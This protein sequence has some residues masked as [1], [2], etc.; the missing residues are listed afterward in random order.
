MSDDTK[1][2]DERLR[3]LRESLESN[4]LT[5]LTHTSLIYCL[6]IIDQLKDENESLWFMLEEH[7]NSKWTSEHSAELEKTIQGQLDMLKLMQMRKGEA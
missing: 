2:D 7:K 6:D 4:D 1:Y 3:A 5:M